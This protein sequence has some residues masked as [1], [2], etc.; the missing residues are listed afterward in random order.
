MTCALKSDSKVTC[1]SRKDTFGVTF[2]TLGGDP[3]S[4]FVATSD[5]V[6]KRGLLEKGFFRK[7]S[8]PTVMIRG[9]QKGVLRGGG[10]ISENWGRA[11]TI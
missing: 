3:E 1:L 8:I 4:H 7:S 11:R 6:W 5:Q 9:F 2:E 10:G